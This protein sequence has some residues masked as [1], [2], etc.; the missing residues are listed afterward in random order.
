MESVHDVDLLRSLHLGQ[1]VFYL[2]HDILGRSLWYCQWAVDQMGFSA[3]TDPV[4]E[5][6]SLYYAHPHSR[7]VVAESRHRISGIYRRFADGGPDV[8]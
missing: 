4:A 3:G 7:A 2:A 5:D 6:G 1:C 8:I